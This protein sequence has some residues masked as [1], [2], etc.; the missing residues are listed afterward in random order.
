MNLLFFSQLFYPAVYGGGEYLFFLITRELARRGHDVHV[1]TQLLE[2]TERIEILEG[3]KIH[4]VGSKFVFTGT[5]PPTIRHNLGYVLGSTRKAYQIILEYKKKGEKFDVIHSNPYVPILCGHFC[6]KVYNIPHIASLYDVYQSE[7]K[8]FWKEW[9]LMDIRNAPFYASAFAKIIE[10]IVLKFDVSSFHT[11]SE[12]S[13]EDL[14]KFGVRSEKITIIPPGIEEVSHVPDLHYNKQA[15]V[16]I[17][18]K[19]NEG[20]TTCVESPFIEELSAVFIGRLIFYKN[21]DTVIAAFKRVIEAIPNARLYI[22]G[23]GPRKNALQRQ[24]EYSNGRIIFTG[25]I[26]ESEKYDII[27]KSSF[28]VFPS[29]FEGFGIVIIESFACGRPVL[30]SDVRPLSDIVKDGYTGFTVSRFDTDD[31]ANK[32]IYLFRNKA[33]LQ[34]MGD[35]AFR[36]FVSNY[37]LKKIV[38]ELEKL[39]E[40]VC[41]N[42]RTK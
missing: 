1:I 4:R 18:A 26:S 34:E 39:Y 13:K 11:I 22:V 23:D 24:A 33:K 20:R 7:N 35:N 37:H 19:N 14:M 29:L 36:E 41:H 42:T 3:I 12:M 8:K 25:R 2:E 27:R 40:S 38:S 21:I 9:M 16:G 28:G 30:I 17:E 5:L 15:S 32:M 6:A 31:W 10:R